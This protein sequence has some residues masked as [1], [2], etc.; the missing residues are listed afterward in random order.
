M[1]SA[2][3]SKV[4]RYQASPL[5]KKPCEQSPLGSK[6]PSHEVVGQVDES[7]IVVVEIRN[8]RPGHR[9]AFGFQRGLGDVPP[10]PIVFHQHDQLVGPLA[11][12]GIQ[13]H[14]KGIVPSLVVK[15]FSS[16]Q[17]DCGLVVHGREIENAVGAWQVG[18]GDLEPGEAGLL[19]ENILR[20]LVPCQSFLSLATALTVT[21]SSAGL[22]LPAAFHFHSVML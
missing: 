17:E 19:V 2:G 3:I 10:A 5:G 20:G 7:P 1:S 18:K 6:L 16:V 8:F 9:D 21:S 14:V 11:P 12:D 22:S 13:W 4:L 15:K